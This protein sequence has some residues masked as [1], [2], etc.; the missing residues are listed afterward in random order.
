MEKELYHGLVLFSLSYCLLKLCSGDTL[1][2]RIKAAVQE[3]TN[4]TLLFHRFDLGLRTQPELD[5]K[6]NQWE[7]ELIAWENDKTQPNPFEERVKSKLL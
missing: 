7:I 6:I 4:Q 1:L 3:S 5:T 2:R